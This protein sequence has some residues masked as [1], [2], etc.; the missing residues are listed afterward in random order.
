MRN[1]I[2][3]GVVILAI[4]NGICAALANGYDSMK[5]NDPGKWTDKLKQETSIR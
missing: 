1:K 5:K 4:F 2:L 3:S